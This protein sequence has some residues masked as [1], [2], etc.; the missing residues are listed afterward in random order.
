MDDRERALRRAAELGLD[1]LAGGDVAAGDGTF[2]FTA[3][4]PVAAAG[5][6]QS[7]PS[8]PSSRS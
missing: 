1:Y 2:S 5:A 8:T 6:S 3:T 4:I 7:S